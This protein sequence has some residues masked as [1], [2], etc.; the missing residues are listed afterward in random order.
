MTNAHKVGATLVLATIAAGGFFAQRAGSHAQLD[1]A[2]GV[3]VA[4]LPRVAVQ[5]TAAVTRIEI[6]RPEGDD[7]ED[8]AG[9]R[10]TVLERRNQ[11]WYLSSPLRARAS[12][13]KISDLLENLATIEVTQVVD[14]AGAA[15]EDCGLSEAKALHV[16]AFQS[17]V[18][19]ADLYFGRTGG[20]G[21]FVRIGG[22]DGAFAVPT[23]GPGSYSGFLYTRSRR[24]WRETSLLAFDASDAVEVEITNPHGHFLFQRTDGSWTASFARRDRRGTLAAPERAWTAFDSSKVDELLAT[25]RSLSADD[26]GDE[27]QRASSGVDSAEETGGGVRIRLRGEATDRVIK[28]G[29]LSTNTGRWAIKDSRWAVDDDPDGSL[30]ALAPWTARWALADATMFER[31]S[32][33]ADGGPALVPPNAEARSPR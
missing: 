14:C 6:T 7:D 3:D 29:K 13:A 22:R 25:F 8:P 33:G 12:A 18:R 24:T 31:R 16:V 17:D 23:T 2:A 30:F 10:T 15:A 5:D 32:E 11:R 27:R 9:P 28:V 21:R 26:F 4:P 19:A 1:P 20:Q